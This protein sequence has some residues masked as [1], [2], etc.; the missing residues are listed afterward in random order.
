MT[1]LTRR[2][3]VITATVATITPAMAKSKNTIK[4]IRQNAYGAPD[5]VIELVDLPMPHAG[6][7]E[8]AIEIE[9]AA[10][11]LADVK[12]VVG[13]EGF[14]TAPL[15]R[16]P[17]FEGV[18][19]IVEVGKDVKGWKRGDRVFP[20]QGSGTFRQRLVAPAERVVSAPDKG[21]A[22][23]LALTTIN[24]LTAYLLL[25]DHTQAQPGEWIL[26]NAANASVGRYLF[27]LAKRKG[28]RTIGFVR[29]ESLI[30]ELK[31]TG[32]DVVLVDT[33]NPNEMAAKVKA[34]TGGVL[35]KAGIDCVAGP[36]TTTVA[37]CVEPGGKVINYGYM[38]GQACHLSFI[39][40]WQRR[41]TLYGMSLRNP[42]SRDEV[43]KL[44]EYLA[45]LIAEGT[46]RAA[47]A[48]A[49]PLD[50]VVEA[51]AH[52][53]RSGDDRQGKIIIHP[54]EFSRSM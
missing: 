36:A 20:P 45:G 3:A 40:L 13:E 5:Q 11:H 25:E 17:G 15:P 35:A 50:K 4:A 52:A 30:P 19:R 32:A 39:D 34:A 43:Q 49:Y 7:G 27:V 38:S 46:L 26:Q 6:P 31:A 10:L 41:I 28:V 48:K 51:L 1:A 16:W 2:S 29:R 47:I 9:A 33:G 44:Y 22:D 42:R 23:Q 53:T 14:D 8:V 18:G 21:D 54:N 24:G 12:Y 37:R